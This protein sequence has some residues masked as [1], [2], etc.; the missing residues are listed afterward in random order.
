MATSTPQAVTQAFITPHPPVS[1]QPSSSSYSRMLERE[2]VLTKGVT[3]F[4]ISTISSY[5][6]QHMSNGGRLD[7][8][9]VGV[10]LMFGVTKTP[11]YSHFWYPQ[12]DK[13]TS[14]PVYR[15]IIDQ[16]FWRPFLTGY[17]FII[18]EL[19]KG[20]NWEQ[21]KSKFKAE[22]WKTTKAGLRIWPVA[23]IINQGL[24]PLKWRTLFKDIIG[25]GWDMYLTLACASAVT[26]SN[27]Q[28]AETTATQRGA[29][30][31]ALDEK[32]RTKIAAEEIW[33]ATGSSSRGMGK[34]HCAAVPL[35]VV[36]LAI[37]FW[38]D[39]Q[40]KGKLKAR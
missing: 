25:F 18:M 1:R 6:A 7:A 36:V 35:T 37:M 38:V 3:S 21:I 4:V 11:P 22:Y 2:P 16:V 14:N 17:T 40:M 8:G 30:N 5:T 10:A 29:H 39:K 28:R 27:T 23:E 12:L 15:V 34:S 24:V 13:I 20:H 32:G 26:K 19:I 33:P 31:T 9:T